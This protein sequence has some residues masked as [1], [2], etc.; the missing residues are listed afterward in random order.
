[1]HKYL[2]PTGS[3]E[4]IPQYAELLLVLLFV[5]TGKSVSA[6]SCAASKTESYAHWQEAS[7]ARRAH[8]CIVMGQYQL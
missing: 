6:A 8:G 5:P 2:Y 1:M 3:R 4:T 7:R